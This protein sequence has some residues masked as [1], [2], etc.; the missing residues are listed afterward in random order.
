MDR[1]L[2]KC[3]RTTSPDYGYQKVIAAKTIKILKKRN[4]VL[5]GAYCGAGKSTIMTLIIEAFVRQH[6]QHTRVLVL[7]ENLNSLKEQYLAHL[8]N[9]HNPISFSYG[10]V[11]EKSDVQVKVG[12]AASLAALEWQSVDLLLVDEVHRQYNGARINSFIRKLGP[13]KEVLFTGSPSKFIGESESIPMVTLSGEELVD[14]G[15]YS[16]CDL[17]VTRTAAKENPHSVLSAF[18]LHA[19]QVNAHLSKVL[20]VCPTIKFAETINEILSAGGFKTFLSTSKND[21]D[22]SILNAAK[23]SSDGFLISVGKC[24][25]GFNDESIR[26]L[27]D[28]RSTSTAKSLDASNQI[29]SRILRRAP[30]GARKSYFRVSN[31]DSESY[32]RQVLVLHK[33]KELMRD[34]IFRGYDGTNLRLELCRD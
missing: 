1:Q 4:K 6:G 28:C 33:L 16:G 22:N 20:I 13:I 11:N 31:A 7:C 18:L 10:D 19:K 29:F 2:N 5:V 24:S 3:I 17:Y 25:L 30:D 27:L 34:S 26:T 8:A 14:K 9:P 21:S 23:A 12:I 32:N 15:V